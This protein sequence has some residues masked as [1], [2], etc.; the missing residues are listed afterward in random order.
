MASIKGKSRPPRPP[1]N[2]FIGFLLLLCYRGW[3]G[4]M[5]LTTRWAWVWV[6]SRSW[7]WTG[8]PGVLRFIGSQSRTRLSDWTELNWMLSCSVVPN[9]LQT[10]AR[11]PSVQGDSPGKNTRVGCLALLQGI[12]P[13]Q[14]SNP[15]LPHCRRILYRLSHQGSKFIIRIDL[16]FVSLNYF[17]NIFWKVIE[18]EEYILT[19]HS[20]EENF[21]EIATALKKNIYWIMQH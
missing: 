12:F 11:Q 8:R 6:N 9:S 16:L 2:S 17:K 14:G 1:G 3:D 21:K 7:W 13:T 10:I 4:W 20:R 18:S 5:A 19:E 15:S